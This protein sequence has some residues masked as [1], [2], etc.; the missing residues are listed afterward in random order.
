MA[1]DII[2]LA[3][4]INPG[5]HRECVT[6]TYKIGLHAKKSYTAAKFLEEH[7]SFLLG[8]GSPRDPA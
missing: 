2:F 6:S 8:L 7:E 1:K 3:M 4:A 5:E